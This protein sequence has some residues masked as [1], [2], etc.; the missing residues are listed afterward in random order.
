MPDDRVT[1]DPAVILE[2]ERD[3][4]GHAEQVL[5]RHP[6]NAVRGEVLAKIGMLDVRGSPA[7]A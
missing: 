1:Q 7:A 5:G 3:P 4:P 2:G 6:G